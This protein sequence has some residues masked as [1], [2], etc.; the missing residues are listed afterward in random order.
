MYLVSTKSCIQRTL[1]TITLT[2]ASHR[3]WLE[4]RESAEANCKKIKKKKLPLF[5]KLEARAKRS[6]Y[7]SRLPHSKIGIFLEFLDNSDDLSSLSLRSLLE[8]ERRVTI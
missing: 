6:S 1:W 8:S 3:S 7:D 4:I 2:K 5:D